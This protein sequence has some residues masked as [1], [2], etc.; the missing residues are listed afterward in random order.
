MEI[1]QD[2]LRTGT[3]KAV[4]CLMSFA[5]ITCSTMIDSSFITIPGS[6]GRCGELVPGP[7][8][9]SVDSSHCQRWWP[10]QPWL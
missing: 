2:N 8:G 4:V 7:A 6:S 3:A 1:E 5:Q 10:C 9:R